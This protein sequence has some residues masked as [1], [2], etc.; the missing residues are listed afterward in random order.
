MDKLGKFVI[1][2]NFSLNKN[3]RKAMKPYNGLL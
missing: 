1:A 2:N 3:G